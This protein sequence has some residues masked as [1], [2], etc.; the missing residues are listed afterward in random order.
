MYHCRARQIFKWTNV[1]GTV[2]PFKKLRLLKNFAGWSLQRI[3]SVIEHT[4][5]QKIIAL[6]TATSIATNSKMFA[7]NSFEKVLNNISKLRKMQTY[8]PIQSSIVLWETG[9]YQSTWYF[10]PCDIIGMA[11]NSFNYKVNSVTEI[12]LTYM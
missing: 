9:Y 6:N 1:T 4:L 11:H 8:F 5:S 12:N 3:R 7:S 2:V 10:L